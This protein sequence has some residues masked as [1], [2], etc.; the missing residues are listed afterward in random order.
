MKRIITISGTPGSGKSTIAKALVKKFGAKRVYVGQY[1]RSLAKKQK[2]TLAELNKLAQSDPSID[3]KAD[4][5]TAKRARLLAKKY[6]V[7]VEGRVQFYF[8][9][10]SSKLFIKCN[11]T[12]A[13]KRIWKDLQDEQKNKE[14][15]EAKVKNIAGLQKEIVIRK[16]SELLRYKKYYKLNHYLPKHYDF[17]LDTSHITA[18]QAIEK[19]LLFLSKKSK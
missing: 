6:P 16:K 8:L 15:N 17:I 13:A 1:M 7:I 10:E 5:L 12:E 14:R 2:M 9:P 4:Q 3:I 11:V 19:T 18:E